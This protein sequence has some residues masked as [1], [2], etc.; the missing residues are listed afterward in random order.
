MKTV[1]IGAALLAAQLAAP[2][3]AGTGEKRRDVPVNISDLDLGTREG[4]AALDRRLA[5]AVVK[6]CGT[7][8]YL[9]PEQLNEVDRCRA[10]ARDRAMATRAKILGGE[11]GAAVGAAGAFR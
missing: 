9:E 8:H 7:A 3:A 1:L 6:A 10:A 4:V 5:R 2:A 11:A